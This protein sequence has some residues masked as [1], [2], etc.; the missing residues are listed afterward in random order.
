MKFTTATAL[1]A[2]SGAAVAAKDERTFAVL[3][4]N[5][6]QLTVARAD[7]IVNPDTVGTHVHH[8]LGGSNFGISATGEDLMKSKCTNAKVNGD[9]SNYWVPS[10]YFKD[11]KTGM[12][13]D[14]EL[15]YANV[16]YL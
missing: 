15:F 8:V 10:L 12:L 7:P 5:N 1:A 14:V 4:F 16:Y 13:E 6:K 3:H 11:P 9:H 2:L